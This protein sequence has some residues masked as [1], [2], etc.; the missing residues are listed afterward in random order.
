MKNLPN[1]TDK[2]I[3]KEYL[4]QRIEYLCELKKKKRSKAANSAPPTK[5]STLHNW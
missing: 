4:I 5:L 1:T 3:L 2:E